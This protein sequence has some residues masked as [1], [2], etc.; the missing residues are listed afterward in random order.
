MPFPQPITRAKVAVRDG[1]LYS[2]RFDDIY[3]SVAGG[4]EEAR[5]VFVAGNQLPKR[6]EEVGRFTIVETGFGCGLNFLAAWD[7]LNRSNINTR[8]DF[9]S[10]EKH[11]FA[12]DD[13]ARVLHA[14]PQLGTLAH[15]L[16]EVYPPLTPGFHRLHPAP[17]ATAATYSVAAK[18]KHGLARAGFDVQKKAGFAHKREMLA[19]RFPGVRETFAETRRVIV[20][21]AGIAG[22]SCAL[23][24]AR[25]GIE[26]DL[27]ERASHPGAETSSNPAALVR[28]FVTLD[29]GVRSRFG[30]AAFLYA[31]RRYRELN[32][33]ANFRWHGTGV[34][35]LARDKAHLKRLQRALAQFALPDSLV[36]LVDARDATGLCGAPIREPGLWCSS[37]GYVDGQLACQAMVEKGGASIALIAGTEAARV[38]RSDRGLQV[39]DVANNLLAQG[40]NVILANGCQAQALI[41]EHDLQLRPVRGQVTEI[42]L[43]SSDLRTPV[44]RDGYVTPGVN[45]IH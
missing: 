37:A 21:G 45:G 35:Q 40:D 27:I 4:I 10:V 1:A 8:L 15:D 26:V 29:S 31:V 41:A 18:A 17:G 36:R 38:E 24:L 20:V 30:W 32:N 34:L 6:W 23:A 13:L 44:C 39:L 2:D 5:H 33:Q 11:P 28:P 9:V 43:T 7:E 22:A 12:R 14:W 16:L 42:P 19:A 3:H 25:Q